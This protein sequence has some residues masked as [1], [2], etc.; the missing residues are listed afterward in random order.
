MWRFCAR[1]RACMPMNGPPY[2]SMLGFFLNLL[3]LYVW[4][5]TH[6]TLHVDVACY[7]WLGWLASKLQES[8]CLP[9]PALRLM[10]QGATSDFLCG[11]NWSPWALMAISL[12][13]SHI[14]NPS[15][16]CVRTENICLLHNKSF[17]AYLY[18]SSLLENM[19]HEC[20][21]FIKS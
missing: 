9:E 8:F 1:D 14:S 20:E 3:P 7:Y 2:R 19:R 5:K 15:S 12:L 18:S 11:L 4:R 17:T 10:T 21:H 13:L 6:F 16:R